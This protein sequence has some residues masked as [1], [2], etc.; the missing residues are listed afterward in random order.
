MPRYVGVCDVANA[1]QSR[2]LSRTLGGSVQG[3]TGDLRPTLMAGIMSGYGTLNEDTTNKWWGIFP[4][5]EDIATIFN[6]PEHVLKTVHYYD[7]HGNGRDVAESIRNVLG[8]AGPD[9]D[10]LQL[11][12]TF[13]DPD[14]VADG[15]AMS[16]KSPWVVLQVGCKALEQVDYD[17]SKLVARL[18][19]Y[20]PV[21]H[22]VL[23][24][25]SMGKGVEINPKLLAPLM[26]AIRA[27]YPGLRI[28]GAGKLGP[29]NAEILQPLLDVIP[30][31]CVDA[32]SGLRPSGSNM[33][34]LDEQYASK[35]VASVGALFLAH[36]SGVL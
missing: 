23:L 17:S 20:E 14:Q 8:F 13:P 30:D 2:R 7:Y 24:D 19:T 5:N 6:G 16:G 1:A 4:R 22:A 26:I 32:Q 31:L 34:P 25:M 10:A 27:A 28:A 29:T 35:Y 12:M 33:D 3:L 9:V 21:I 11:D 15:I 36:A 18:R